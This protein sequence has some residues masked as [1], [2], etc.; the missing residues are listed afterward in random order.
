MRIFP[1]AEASPASAPEPERRGVS[2]W[3][4]IGEGAQA[5]SRWL[6]IG[7]VVLAPLPFGSVEA[8]WTALWCMTMALSLALTGRLGLETGQRRIIASVLLVYALFLGVIALQAGNI[9]PDPLWDR[10]AALLDLPLQPRASASQTGSIMALGNS[11]LL[12]MTF[13]RIV[14]LAADRRDAERL[15]RI[16]AWAGLAYALF[17]VV[18]FAL[19]PTTVL[20]R[21]KP[22]Y[23]GNLTGTFINRNTAATFFGSLAVF[24]LLLLISEI[25]F[26]RSSDLRASE[27]LWLLAHGRDLKPVALFVGLLLCVAATAATGSRA[28]FVLTLAVLSVA[29]CLYARLT[30]ARLRSHAWAWVA[31][32]ILIVLFVEMLGGSVARRVQ[33]MGLDDQNRFEVYRASLD[34]IAQHPWLGIGLGNF[35]AVFP[36]VRPS[37]ILIAGFWD[38]AHST[39]LEIAIEMGL[40]FAGLAGLLWLWLGG[41]L[42]AGSL[43]RR[44]P[45]VIAGCAVG[46]LGTLHSLVDF[47]LQIP[48]YAVLFAAATGLGLACA[49]AG[50]G[51][52]GDIRIRAWR[53]PSG[54][55][56]NGFRAW[57]LAGRVRHGRPSPR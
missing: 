31:A 6:A 35:A 50:P 8:R 5:L 13:C 7:T 37:T 48:G 38:R 34:L 9:Q 51:I 36:S 29:G 55:G 52:S 44:D 12:V 56:A 16:L 24:W 20:W 3:R 41:K 53:S 47:S 39:P 23:L 2:L 30:V 1:A 46:L 49:S 27:R 10:A 21:S 18:S 4:R 28:G 17:A 54:R 32:A 25:R 15:F 33:M 45:L 22:A 19:D 26:G 40:P 14:L 11:L 43:R 42:I 57:R